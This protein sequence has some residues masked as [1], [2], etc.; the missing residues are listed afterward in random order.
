M[1]S[2]EALYLLGLG[3]VLSPQGRT[4]GWYWKNE[5]GMELWFNTEY[6]AYTR[7]QEWD[8]IN[9]AFKEHPWEMLQ[10]GQDMVNSP[11][12]YNQ[13][14]IEVIDI[15]ETYF[16]DNYHLGNA[17]KYLLRCQYKGHTEEDLQKCI[18]YINRFMTHDT[19]PVPELPTV[20]GNP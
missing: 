11:P 15:I 19:D 5:D 17:C 18:W 12:H 10:A 3:W 7:Q 14:N 6:A 4:P 16:H 9:Q 20:E 13:H 2:R 1:M 8:A